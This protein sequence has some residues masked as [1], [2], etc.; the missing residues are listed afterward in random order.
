MRYGNS[1]RV[2]LLKKSMLHGF[3]A[4]ANISDEAIRRSKK[5]SATSVMKSLHSKNNSAGDLVSERPEKDGWYLCKVL[6]VNDTI[7][8]ETVPF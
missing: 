1:R 3:E 2:Y 6:Y 4:K 5:L 7:G 8:E